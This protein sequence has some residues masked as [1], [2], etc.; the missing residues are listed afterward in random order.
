VSYP[1]FSPHQSR[2]EGFLTIVRVVIAAAVAAIAGPYVCAAQ[3]VTEGSTAPFSNEAL[4]AAQTAFYN[5][6]YSDAAAL[7][8]NSCTAQPENLAG[9]E[10]R[11]SALL[12]QLRDALE[13]DSLK[14]KDKG[15]A[16]KECAQCQA[17]LDAFLRDTGRGQAA[18]RAILRHDPNNET[19][20]FFLGKLDINYVWLHLGPLGQ[21]TGWDEY[22]EA[23]KSLD[24]VLKANPR[25]VRARVARAWIDYIVDTRM[26]RG[27][28]WILGGGSRKRALT[29]VR[30]A[31]N[32]DA[33]YFTRIEAKFGLWDMQV[34]EK[35]L[36]EAIP[37]ARELALEFP[38][39][40]ELTRFLAVHDRVVSNRK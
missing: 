8:I 23:R 9:C 21:R 29:T 6:R 40:V 5:A 14:D 24:A 35:N 7:T 20:L 36:T 17:L 13:D 34:R 19:A 33:D 11:T 30:E 2:S 25:H 10:L 1:C 22:W 38:T 32:T 18:A 3:V 28:R 12:F 27:T 26:P 31:V 39:N 16:L 37:L 15:K 4:L